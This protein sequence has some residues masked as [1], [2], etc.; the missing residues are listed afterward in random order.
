MD[1]NNFVLGLDFGTDSVR[2]VLVDVSSGRESASHIFSY[3]RWS[4]GKYCD[5]RSNQFRQHPLDYL[6]GLEFSIK[7][8]LAKVPPDTAAKVAGIS[9]DTTGSTP[10][11]VDRD[12][13]ALALRSEFSE[14]PEA[15]FILWKDHTAVEEAAEINEHARN[16][17]GQDFTRYSGGV[18]SSEWFWAKILHTIRRDEAIRKAA[19]SW[20]EH[21]DWIPAVLTGIT[22]PDKL[23]R[24][25]CAAGHKAMWHEEWGVTQRGLPVVA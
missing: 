16:W 19:W 8:T 10:V 3:P 1:D 2:A 23:K 13:T 6:E 17:G 14:N 18:Y 24:S 5:S 20:V 21:C 9:V 22:A 7:G 25:R 11:A 4:A 12:G 15:M